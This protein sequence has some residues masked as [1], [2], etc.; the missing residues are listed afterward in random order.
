MA[1]SIPPPA[2]GSQRDR[3]GHGRRELRGAFRGTRDR[4]DEGCRVAVIGGGI[5]G[6]AAA[7]VLAERGAKVTLF[8]REPFLGGRAG[9][10]AER[11]GDGE[12]FRMER[13]FPAVARHYYNF[14]ALYRRIDPGLESLRP[15]GDP[16]VMDEDGVVEVLSGLPTTP[17]LNVLALLRRTPFLSMSE[18]R[19]IDVATVRTLLTFDP[20]RSYA[21]H[22]AETAAAYLDRLALPP[23][24]RQMLVRVFCR[25]DA[26]DETSLSAAE[27]LSLLHFHFL[28][29]P[30]GMALDVPDEPISDAFFSPIQRQLAQ[31]GAQVLLGGRVDDVEHA[32]GDKLVVTANTGTLECDG[33]VIALDVV[34]AQGLFARSRHLRADAELGK[35]IASLTTAPPFC[36]W[37]AFL[38]KS[39]DPARPAYASVLGRPTALSVALHERIEGESRRWSLRTGGSVVQMHAFGLSPQASEADVRAELRTALDRLYPELRGAVTLHEGFVRAADRAA[40]P[41]GSA[42]SRPRVATPYGNVAF[43]GDWVKL[44]FPAAHVERAAASGLMAANTLLDRWDVRGEPIWTIP[45]RGFVAAIASGRMP[46]RD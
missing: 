14:R 21:E 9:A 37:R 11:L 35:S 4:V 6:I 8:E 45:P 19:K 40:F 24:A 13:S 17:P 29:N 38:D 25:A 10:P 15:L 31:L 20:Q 1:S 36:V 41:A 34:G 39:A 33:L 46:G 2:L 30:E 22:D 7:L 23:R 26:H 44:P 3:L 32:R 5:A 27:M 28:G 42:A 18:L 12:S 16:T 43:A